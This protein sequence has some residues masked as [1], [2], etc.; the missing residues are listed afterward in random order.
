[1]ELEFLTEIRFLKNQVSKQEHFAGIF[2][3]NGYFAILA[4][5][6]IA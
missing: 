1:M 2:G 4:N 3:W 5:V 6:V